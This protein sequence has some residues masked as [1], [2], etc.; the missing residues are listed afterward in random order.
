[1]N[2]EIISLKSGIID[3]TLP[4]TD[5][6]L[7]ILIRIVQGMKEGTSQTI[8]DKVSND[9][10]DE[11]SDNIP[12]EE[13]FKEEIK[14]QSLSP[15]SPNNTSLFNHW[16]KENHIKCFEISDFTKKYSQIGEETA[17][18]IIAHKIANNKL[19]QLSKTRFRVLEVD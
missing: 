13:A 7:D 14:K 3:V 16:I 19:Q 2:E 6:N 8:P 4:K 5:E 11:V 1:M 18:K 9:V 15:K 10:P 17:I 12:I